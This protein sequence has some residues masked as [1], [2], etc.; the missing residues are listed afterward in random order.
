L[1]ALRAQPRRRW[2]IVEDRRSGRSDGLHRRR[3][4]GREKNYANAAQFS[5]RPIGQ[6]LLAE[7]VVRFVGEPV[8]VVVATS[9]AEAEDLSEQ[10]ELSIDETRAI[11]DARMAL[12]A[13]APSVHVEV[14]GNVILEGKVKTPGFDETW[15]DADK[16][17]KLEAR[18]RRQ[19]ATPMEPRGGHASYEASSGRVTLTC[20][21]QMPHLTRTAICD[22]L[23]FPE[24][25]L[26][27]IAPD[28]GGGFGQ[29]MSLAA[30]MSCWCGWRES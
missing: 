20:S 23:G 14:P 11:S 19:N 26:R 30:N 22:V 10:V 13:S 6:P 8:A 15:A 21:T 9:A 7:S 28:V 2:T 4:Q 25:D 27:V 18:S 29:K 24:S 3:S 12:E 5:Y 16:I 1:G 17:I